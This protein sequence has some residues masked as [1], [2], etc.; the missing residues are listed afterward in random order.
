MSTI[1]SSESLYGCRT[2]MAMDHS[3][4]GWELGPPGLPGEKFSYGS[5][6]TSVACADTQATIIVLPDK[7]MSLRRDSCGLYADETESVQSLMDLA[8][9]G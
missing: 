6:P 2:S 3:E 5:P 4:D 1:A 7:L 9:F 8:T